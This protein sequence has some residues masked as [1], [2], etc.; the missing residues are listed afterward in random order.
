[1]TGLLDSA[2]GSSAS[3]RI[4]MA[5]P[6]PRLSASRR[7]AA[8]ALRKAL[9]TTSF[10][11]LSG[12]ERQWRERIEAKRAE[13]VADEDS[14]GP[15]F[16]P[17]SEGERGLFTMK[18]ER[19]TVAVAASMMSLTPTW[20]TLLMRF[21]RELEPRTCLELGTGFGISAAYQAAAL[22][23]NGAGRLT[24]LEGSADWGE[25]ARR[26]LAELGLASVDLIA[27]PIAET[28]PGEAERLDPLD[29]VYIDAE[30]QA[31]ATLDHFA[32][33]EPH[34]PDGA[35]VV[36]DD[37]NWAE[38]REAHAEIAKHRRVASSLVIGRLGFTF[39]DAAA[40]A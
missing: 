11:R 17:G 28:L 10:D 8:R 23:L 4:R 35:V 22:E 38:M 18:R 27:G 15:A 2:R 30:H 26:S 19:T 20:C 12:P 24:T 9:A 6:L 5:A 25:R 37:V 32:T 16:E 3:A 39:V 34:L 1:M 31:Q 29:Y 14:T 13:L 21:V 36:F 33:L 40:A 7:P